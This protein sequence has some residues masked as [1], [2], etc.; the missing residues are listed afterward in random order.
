MNIEKTISLHLQQGTILF[1]FI[2]FYFFFFFCESEFVQKEENK[3]PGLFTFFPGFI[4]RDSNSPNTAY[5]Q[6]FSAF[7]IVN[8]FPFLP[9]FSSA[10]CIYTLLSFLPLQICTLQGF[11][12]GCI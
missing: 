5:M 10:Y 4:F 12:S 11:T 7:G 9:D 8:I 1:M 3:I 6:D 2:F